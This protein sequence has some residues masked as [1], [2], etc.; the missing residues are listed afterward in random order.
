MTD[1]TSDQGETPAVVVLAVVV[2]DM[3]GDPI[4]MGCAG[5]DSDDLGE[6]LASVP[7]L[8]RSIVRQAVAE[9]TRGQGPGTRQGAEMGPLSAVLSDREETPGTRHP[10]Y[11]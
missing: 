3:D 8:A 4:G 1:E 6:M 10:G 9:Q 5:V 11:L 7:D 2:V